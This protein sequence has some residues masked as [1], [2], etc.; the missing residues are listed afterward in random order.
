MG[1]SI[2]NKPLCHRR[3]HSMV[4]SSFVWLF[5]DSGQT[6]FAIDTVDRSRFSS[7]GLQSL[8]R[9]S[10]GSVFLLDYSKIPHHL[11]CVTRKYNKIQTRFF[12]IQEKLTDP[13]SFQCI[14][15]FLTFVRLLDGFWD[16][17]PV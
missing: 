11:C 10:F 8:W 1:F 3:H 16:E 13:L 5:F 7:T 4:S 9:H 2:R 6:I 17:K 14:Q 15:T 12:F